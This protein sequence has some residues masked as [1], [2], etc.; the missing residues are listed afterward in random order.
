VLRRSV[1]V[2][3]TAH[4]FLGVVKLV[5]T[6]AEERR[7]LEV[8]DVRLATFEFVKLDAQRVEDAPHTRVV[9]KHHSAHLVRRRHVRTLVR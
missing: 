2:H 1:L 9:R 8:L 3:K 6:I 4:D 7:L 5:E